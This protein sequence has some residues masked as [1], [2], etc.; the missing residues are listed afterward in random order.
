M[1]Q[2]T[3]K[4]PSG[5]ISHAVSPVAVRVCPICAPAPDLAARCRNSGSYFVRLPA[6]RTPPPM[7]SCSTHQ[8]S[9]RREPVKRFL[10]VRFSPTPFGRTAV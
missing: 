3:V 8:K 6:I 2:A 1:T 7:I 5:P 9:A 4:L 10:T